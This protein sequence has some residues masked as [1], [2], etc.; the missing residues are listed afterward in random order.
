MAL[1]TCVC[2]TVLLTDN[3]IA[4]ADDAATEWHYVGGTLTYGGAETDGLPLYISCESG[5]LKATVAT[6]AKQQQEG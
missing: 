1:T 3:V 6:Y 4:A 5:R 2:T